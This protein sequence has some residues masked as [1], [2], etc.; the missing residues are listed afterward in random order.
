V[1]Q[2]KTFGELKLGT[3]EKEAIQ[4]ATLILKKQFPVEDIILFGSKARGDSDPESDIDLLLLTTKPLNWK[5]RHEIVDALFDLEMK[6]DVVISII[7]NTLHD[8]N[9]GVC[10]VLPIHDKI[11]GE[12][13]ALQ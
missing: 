7:V 10:T 11:T 2:L 3:N 5:E 1:V 6:H 13:V 4:E 12:G 9:E 8:W